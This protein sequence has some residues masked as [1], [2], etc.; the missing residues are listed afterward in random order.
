MHSRCVHVAFLATCETGVTGSQTVEAQGRRAGRSTRWSVSAPP[1][2]SHRRAI[3]ASHEADDLPRLDTVSAEPTLTTSWFR[4]PTSRP[5]RAATGPAYRGLHSGPRGTTST[6][7]LG[8]IT[9]TTPRLRPRWRGR[10]TRRTWNPRL[11]AACGLSPSQ[12]SPCLRAPPFAVW[13][14]SPTRGCSRARRP[15]A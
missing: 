10:L 2:F 14:R 6:V 5:T 9:L 7:T 12:P 13:S 3:A 15:T 11:A 1:P 4:R 8:R